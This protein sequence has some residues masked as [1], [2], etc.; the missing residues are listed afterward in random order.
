MLRTEHDLLTRHEGHED[1]RDLHGCLPVEVKRLAGEVV[2]SI[3]GQPRFLTHF[4][5]RS[6]F[7]SLA[8]FDATVDDFPGSGAARVGG[9]AE[10]QHAQAVAYMSKDK[11]V[12]DADDEVRHVASEIG[13]ATW[14]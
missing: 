3:S 6:R 2:Q 4:S 11:D 13:R 1:H 12:H 14:R 5:Q 10:R 8:W 7:R 9:T